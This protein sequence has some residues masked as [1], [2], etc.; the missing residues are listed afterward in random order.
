[1]ITSLHKPIHVD[2]ARLSD[3]NRDIVPRDMWL[4]KEVAER[5]DAKYPGHAWAVE[6]NHRQG[7][8]N[9]RNLLISGVF[10]YVLKIGAFGSH[11]DL[12]K[13]AERM[14]GEL[15]ERANLSRGVLR[16]AEIMGG[17]A[18]DKGGA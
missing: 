7:I 16:D 1:M 12:L 6:A 4:A 13:E 9:I 18:L 11:L 2:E 14:G 10:G 3:G 17:V 15:L 5:L 8:V